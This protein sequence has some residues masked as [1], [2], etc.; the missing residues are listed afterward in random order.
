[1]GGVG[2]DAERRCL[3]HSLKVF[4]GFEAQLFVVHQINVDSE[5]ERSQKLT[6]RV[7]LTVQPDMS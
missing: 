5:S 7:T 1:M 4:L 2:V 3:V 6:E